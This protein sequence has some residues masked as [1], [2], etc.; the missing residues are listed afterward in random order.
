MYEFCP[1]CGKP[2][3]WDNADHTVYGDVLIWKTAWICKPCGIIVRET[4]TY[5]KIGDEGKI[6]II[7]EDDWE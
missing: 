4:E 2:L 5:N 6:E 1:C 3:Q 7:K